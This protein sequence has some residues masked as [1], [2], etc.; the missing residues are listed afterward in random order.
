MFCQTWYVPTWIKATYANQAYTSN[1]RTMVCDLWY[2]GAS[3]EG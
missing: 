2:C 3:V 1:P